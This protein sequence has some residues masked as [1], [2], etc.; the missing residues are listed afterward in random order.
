MSVP[1]LERF[2]HAQDA[3]PASYA[4]AL[5]EIRR[6]GKRSHWIWYVFPQLEGLATSEYARKYGIH[7]MAEAT[8]FLNDPV[9]GQRLMTITEAVADELRRGIDLEVLMGSHIDAIKLVSS[10]TLFAEAAEASAGLPGL[11]DHRDFA[12]VA[13]EVLTIAAV[14]G[15]PP[16]P[17]TLDRLRTRPA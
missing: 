4:T 6:G 7:D 12:T 14:Q 5:S 17:R 13:R 2:K 11:A 9:L 1:Q 15:F 16:C 3:G 8:A 10:L